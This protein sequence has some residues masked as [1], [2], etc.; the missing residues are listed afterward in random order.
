SGGALEFVDV[1]GNVQLIASDHA[2][3]IYR[4][5]DDYFAVTYVTDLS[6]N[7]GFVQKL[8]RTPEGLWTAEKWRALPGAPRLCWLLKNNEILVSCV[9]G[10]AL[11]APTGEMTSLTRKK[12]LGLRR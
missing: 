1:E 9:G 7:G 12:A 3:A 4:I 8:K 5:V 10:I 11:I 6:M 2:K